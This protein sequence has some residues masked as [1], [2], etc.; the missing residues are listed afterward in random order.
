MTSMDFME[1]RS[2]IS[3]SSPIPRRISVD[4]AFRVSAGSPL[5]PKPSQMGSTPLSLET[6]L[7]P[8]PYSS[9][10]LER[11]HANT[12]RHLSKYL[13]RASID[14]SSP[15]SHMDEDS[16]HT[17]SDHTFMSAMHTT[18]PN[19]RVSRGVD[20]DSDIGPLMRSLKTSTP[21]DLFS[22]FRT[23]REQL[24][25]TLQ[26]H[27]PPPAPTPQ[28][29]EEVSPV[30]PQPT[31]RGTQAAHRKRPRTRPRPRR[32]PVLLTTHAD[33]LL[34][35]DPLPMGHRPSS[36]LR[37]PLMDTGEVLEPLSRT[38]GRLS[39]AG[40]RVIRRSR[41]GRASGYVSSFLG[42]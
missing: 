12:A 11:E 27:T 30:K 2:S 20:N 33:R 5:A 6:F 32:D 17:V 40:R 3:R 22:H 38:M 41:S 1:S 14:M 8:R 18:L 19:T 23:A 7:E 28:Q 21:K 35:T 24:A 10:Y 42:E 36:H 29:E 25:R 9:A 16:Q 15:I 31:T 4:S 13:S 39:P 37:T 34:N 26:Q